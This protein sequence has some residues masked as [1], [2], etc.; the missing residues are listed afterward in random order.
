MSENRCIYCNFKH[1]DNIGAEIYSGEYIPEEVMYGSEWSDGFEY[2][3]LKQ[4][5]GYFFLVTLHSDNEFYSSD[6]DAT[7]IKFC[8]MCGRNLMEEN[9]GN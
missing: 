7:A 6:G 4:K 8:P 2:A 3:F 5:N 1:P 9:N